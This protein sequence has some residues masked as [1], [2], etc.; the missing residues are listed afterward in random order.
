MIA[1]LDVNVLIALFDSAHVHHLRAHEWLGDYRAEGWA[2]CPITENACIRIISQPAYPGR[3][4]M[5]DIASRLRAATAEPDYH[6]WPDS[7]SAL[8]PKLF[9]LDQ[10]L[11]SKYLTDLYLI[12]LAAAND[13]R[14]VTFDRKIPHAAVLSARP[15]NLVVL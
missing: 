13:G 6:F 1:L 11:S 4:A 8:D 9:A 7:V 10:V 14:L 12:A 15:E 2:T 5:A 3:L